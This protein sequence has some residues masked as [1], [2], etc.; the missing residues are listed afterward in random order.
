MAW[1][2]A[3]LLEDGAGAFAASAAACGNARAELE[4]VKAVAG[5]GLALEVTVRNSA[6]DANDHEAA[7]LRCSDPLRCLHYK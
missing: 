7:R 3:H 5:R 2:G 4:L 1:G 6:A